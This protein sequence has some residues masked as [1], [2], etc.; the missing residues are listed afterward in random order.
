MSDALFTNPSFPFKIKM[1]YFLLY[2]Y[3][4]VYQNADGSAFQLLSTL[5]TW[6]R[7]WLR[8][9]TISGTMTFRSPS[10]QDQEL[11]GRD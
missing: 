5:V 11:H 6:S 2:M 8:F 10:I 4:Q 9:S 7:F 3:S 1:N